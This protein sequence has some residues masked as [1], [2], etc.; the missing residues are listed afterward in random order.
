[1]ATPSATGEC[2]PDVLAAAVVAVQGEPGEGLRRLAALIAEHPQ[3]GRL[4]FLQGALLA[5]QRQYGEA[6]TAMRRAV[7]LAP[8]FVLARFQ[9]GFLELTSGQATAALAA[10][11][12]LQ[13]LPAVF[14]V[15]VR[16][17]TARWTFSCQPCAP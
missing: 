2:P 9:L 7:E 16:P 3:D 10:W 12:P 11:G 13:V 4:R 1:M 15:P 5:D 8:D 14:T 17:V 6:A